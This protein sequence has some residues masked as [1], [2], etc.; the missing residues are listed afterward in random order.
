MLG[1]SYTSWCS[2]LHCSCSGRR[3]NC[4]TQKGQSLDISPFFAFLILD[5]F[6]FRMLWCNWAVTTFLC[7]LNILYFCFID[8][9]HLLTS[10][11]F[12]GFN[13]LFEQPFLTDRLYY[14]SSSENCALYFMKCQILVAEVTFEGHLRRHEIPLAMIQFDNPYHCLDAFVTVDKKPRFSSWLLCMITSGVCQ[15]PAPMSLAC[16]TNSSICVLSCSCARCMTT[17]LQWNL[18]F[19]AVSSC[20][21]VLYASSWLCKLYK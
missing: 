5:R 15:R 17:C 8:F 18:L 6:R 16:G 1:V 10:S 2:R 7:N 3:A 12:L 14:T 20:L 21:H 13:A 4:F 11:L 9:R 19:L